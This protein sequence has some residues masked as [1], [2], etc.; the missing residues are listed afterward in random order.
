MHS[1]TKW[2]SFIC[3]GN[4]FP[5]SICLP[6][7]I[8]LTHFTGPA[9]NRGLH[10]I[11]AHKVYPKYLLLNIPVSS[12]LTFS[13]SPHPDPLRKERENKAVIFCG[14]F[15]FAINEP[16]YSPVCCP[17]LSRLS[18]PPGRGDNPACNFAK[19]NRFMICFGNLLFIGLMNPYIYRDG[20][21]DKPSRF[22][23]TRRFTGLN[24]WLILFRSVLI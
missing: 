5:E 8:A 7:P 12:Y 13:P 23:K 20:I 9:K 22:L 2:S 14:T 24:T 3:S 17:A 16:G 10:G 1:I 19:I 15:Y 21:N 18:S 6:S 11:S 4:Y